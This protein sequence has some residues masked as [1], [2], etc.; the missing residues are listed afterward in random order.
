[1]RALVAVVER[2]QHL[3]GGSPA[4]GSRPLEAHGARR[5]R[6]AVERRALPRGDA[7]HGHPGPP[8]AAVQLCAGR[9]SCPA[10]QWR[11]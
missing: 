7:Q 3:M 2:V 6:R 4:A 8:P 1:M 5:R 11:L 9:G 10:S